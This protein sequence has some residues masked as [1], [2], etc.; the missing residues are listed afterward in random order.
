MIHVK[1]YSGSQTLSHLFAQGSVGAHLLL[2][3]RAFRR[4]LDATLPETHRVGSGAVDA[5][6]FE[7]V[8]AIVDGS[9]RPLVEVLPFFSRLMLKNT[10][11]QVG[12]FGYAVSTVGIAVVGGP[13]RARDRRDHVQRTLHTAAS[14]PAAPAAPWVR[15][16]G[17]A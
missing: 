10:A 13:I 2:T 11:R 8:Y 14:S 17:E 6:A 15:E 5:R 12:A 4:K 9:G 16:A 7:V 1:R 3:D